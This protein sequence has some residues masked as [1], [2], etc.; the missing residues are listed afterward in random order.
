MKEEMIQRLS[1]ALNALNNVSVKGKANLNNLV[2]SISV[3]E[4]VCNM[5]NSA[6]I[7]ESKQ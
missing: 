3:I 6:D 1:A 7:M 4:E 2:G 5:L